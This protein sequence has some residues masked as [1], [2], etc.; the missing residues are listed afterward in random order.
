MRAIKS[1]CL[2][3]EINKIPK[4]ISKCKKLACFQRRLMHIKLERTSVDFSG[5]DDGYTINQGE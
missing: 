1:P 2:T 5:D 3:C 4:C